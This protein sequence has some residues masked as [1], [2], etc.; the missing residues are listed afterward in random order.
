MRHIV[1]VVISATL[2]V[3]VSEVAKRS[4]ALGAHGASF[5]LLSV[6]DMIWLWRDTRDPVRFAGHAEATCWYVW[7]DIDALFGRR[8]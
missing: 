3:A 1:S 6:F 4:L 2:V 7:G 5:L 8:T